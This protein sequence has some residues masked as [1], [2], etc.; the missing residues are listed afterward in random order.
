M[1][2]VDEAAKSEEE[3]KDKK[4]EPSSPKTTKP[5]EAVES[6]PKAEADA[7]KDRQ[8]NGSRGTSPKP[9][10]DTDDEDEPPKAEKKPSSGVEGAEDNQVIQ[11]KLT[12]TGVNSNSVSTPYQ[13]PGPK[14]KIL[15][16]PSSTP[17][18]LSI[19]RI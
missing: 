2:E 14:L 3:K 16:R 6:K 12:D 4:T 9:F 5:E 7:A 11:V 8:I 18:Q 13:P 1:G 19:S 10:D 17:S 15:K